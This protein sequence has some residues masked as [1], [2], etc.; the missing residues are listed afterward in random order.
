MILH[1]PTGKQFRNRKEAKKF[2]GTARY[3][4]I[5]KEKI[6]IILIPNHDFIATDEVYKGKQE[7]ASCP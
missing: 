2:F 5:E 3:R 6:E 1:K 7:F 4:K